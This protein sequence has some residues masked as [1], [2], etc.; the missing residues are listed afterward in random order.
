MHPTPLQRKQPQIL[1]LIHTANGATVTKK[2]DSQRKRSLPG[3]IQ[4]A[5]LLANNSKSSPWLGDIL[6]EEDLGYQNNPTTHHIPLLQHYI[7]KGQLIQDLPSLNQSRDWLKQQF[8]SFKPWLKKNNPY[9]VT[10]DKNLLQL[11]KNN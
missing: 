5:R 10:L 2:S 11:S 9:P 1:Q 7:K 4:I 3:R 8:T 6:Y